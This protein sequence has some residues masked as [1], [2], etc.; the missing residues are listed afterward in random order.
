MAKVDEIRVVGLTVVDVEQIKIQFR[1]NRSAQTDSE[2]LEALRELSRQAAAVLAAATNQS[3]LTP[4]VNPT[5]SGVEDTDATAPS[6][7]AQANATPA[8]QQGPPSI[9]TQPDSSPGPP[10]DSEAVR[11]ADAEEEGFDWLLWGVVGAGAVVAT[12]AAV[13]IT[14]GSIALWPPSSVG[15]VP[16]Y[17]LSF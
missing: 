10:P 15:P 8:N 11:T 6:L 13:I 12:G 1:G 16:E 14:V 17:A 3:V 5:T 2:V 9:A 4:G 7:P